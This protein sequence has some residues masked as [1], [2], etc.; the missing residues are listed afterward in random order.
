VR[1]HVPSQAGEARSDHIVGPA[2]E[3]RG[4][5][6]RQ[7]LGGVLTVGVE[8]GHGS[9]T[10]LHRPRQAGAHGGAEP[11]IP[12]ERVNG[13]AAGP[14]RGGGPIAGTVIDDH[15]VHRMPVNLAWSPPDDITD[16]HF[17]VVGGQNHHHRAEARKLWCLHC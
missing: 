14:R 8:E 11:A 7:L 6:R 10:L 1:T 5:Q 13:G 9:R 3:D 16:S 4:H 12:V 17:L 15:D 2:L